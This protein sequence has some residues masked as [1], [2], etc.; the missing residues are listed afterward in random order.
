M[1]MDNR[2]RGH[3]NFT[4]D[5]EHEGYVQKHIAEILPIGTFAC[6]IGNTSSKPDLESTNA[7]FL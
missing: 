1:S 7:S 5:R 3:R 6:G 2:V 4:G